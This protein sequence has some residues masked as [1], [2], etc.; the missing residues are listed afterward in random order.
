MWHE[1]TLK[2]LSDTLQLWHNLLNHV[3]D[4]VFTLTNHQ[5]NN[6]TKHITLCVVG[7]MS[8]FIIALY[9]WVVNKVVET[10][11]ANHYIKSVSKISSIWTCY[12]HISYAHTSCIF[13]IKWITSTC[14]ERAKTLLWL[15]WCEI[16]LLI[17]EHK[18]SMLGRNFG[19]E[20]D[21]VRRVLRTGITRRRLA[22]F[23]KRVLRSSS[24]GV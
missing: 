12:K 15:L 23:I 9:F 18:N 24:K 13:G 4:L 6:V 14:G 22:L 19:T 20:R 2:L 5:Y 16:W 11:T 7:D 8:F 3:T 21:N 17:F 10:C 1:C